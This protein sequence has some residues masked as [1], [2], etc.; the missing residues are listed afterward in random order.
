MTSAYGDITRA[1]RRKL[2]L[3]AREEAAMPE[4]SDAYTRAGRRKLDMDLATIPG[5]S[6]PDGDVLVLDDALWERVVVATRGLAAQCFQCG[7][8]TAICPWGQ[9]KS[10]PV[11]IRRLVREAQ[12]GAPGWPEA[13]W[14][15]TTCGRC[16]ALCPRGVDIPEVILALRGLAWRDRE[17][18][19]GF[20]TLLWNVYWDG[21]PYGRPPSQR[22]DWMKGLDL[23]DF[24]GDQEVL[25]YAGCTASYDPRIQ[26]IARAV[27]Q[28]LR[29]AGV[30]F[31]VLKDREPCCGDAVRNAGHADYADDIAAEG[32]KLFRELGVRTVVTVSPHCLDQFLHHFDMPPEFRALHYTQYLRELIASGRLRVEGELPL[33]V[34]FHDPCYLGRQNG[35]YD[36]PREVLASIPGVELLEMRHNREEALCC[37]GGGGRMWLET[38]ANERFASVRVAEARETGAEIIGSACPHCVSCLEDSIPGDASIRVADVAEIL[39]WALAKP[40]RVE[41]GVAS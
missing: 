38:A 16:E 2:W 1:G 7:V 20:P 28:V 27:V 31:G 41:A 22:S 25:L 37:G 3:D 8:C 30:E 33:K 18:P 11:L 10:E 4:D 32:S 17:E 12:M 5:I 14:L 29:A 21:N 36:S 24:S 35:D 39:A 26:K 23:P 13:V 6:Q 19:Q 40:A 15:C 9:V 34:T